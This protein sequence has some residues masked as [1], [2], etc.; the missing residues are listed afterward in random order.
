MMQVIFS[1][2]ELGSPPFL[3][4]IQFYSNI[5]ETQVGKRLQE[6]ATWPTYSDVYLLILKEHVVTE[7]LAKIHVFI[8][9]R[10]GVEMERSISLC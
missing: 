4:V 9:S 8:S 1:K 2:I 10:L 7:G 5:D 6:I 3:T